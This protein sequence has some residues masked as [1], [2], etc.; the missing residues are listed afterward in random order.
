MPRFVQVQGFSKGG[1]AVTILHPTP[2]LWTQVLNQR[3]QILFQT[4]IAMVLYHLNLRPGSV[5]VESGTGS[6]SLSTSIARAIAPHGHLHTFE[7]NIERARRARSDIALNRLADVV[8]VRHRDVCGRGF[9][10]FP[11]GVD[12]V[13]LDLPTPWVAVDSAHAALRPQGRICSFSPC[14]EQV[15][16]TCLRLSELGYEVRCPVPSPP[17]PSLLRL[18]PSA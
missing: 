8:T 13:F 1:G 3:T 2:Q 11:A 14:I 6:A 7:F 12:A 4:D 9:P 10:A 17:G 16:R 15:Q 18:F 5:V